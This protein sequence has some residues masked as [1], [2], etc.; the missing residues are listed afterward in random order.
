MSGQIT[1]SW[2]GTVLTITS[3]SGTSSADLKG[4]KGDD[5]ARGAQGAQGEQYKPIS[6]VD[7]LTDAEREDI[8]QNT[9]N[10][11]DFPVDSINGKTGDVV[12]NSA[13][14]GARANNWM[15]TAEEVGARANNW[16]PT[17][18]EVGAATPA[19]VN[20]VVN[21]AVKKAAPINLL[22][23]SD[24]RNPVNQR[25]NNSYHDMGYTIDRWYISESREINVLTN[26]IEI[27]ANDIVGGLSQKVERMAVGDVVTFAAQDADG[28]LY[29][30][31]TALSGDIDA[32]I[33]VG[34][35]VKLR[36]ISLNGIGIFSIS[37]IDFKRIFQWAALYEGE[38]TE[39][40]LP[41]Y[42]PKGYA[43]ELL[44]CQRY[45]VELDH[46]ALGTGY[47]STTNDATIFINPPIQM[48]IKPSVIFSG[49]EIIARF[50]G[51]EFA[52]HDCALYAFDKGNS[53]T[54]RLIGYL[55]EGV[56][57]LTVIAAYATS[58]VALSADL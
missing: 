33:D 50:N 15:P 3:D 52:M 40:T 56:Q 31:S 25:G 32:W 35:G 2:N 58:K 13:D 7:Y 6:G 55:H 14:V 38:Y 16:M 53:T 41:E 5:G 39:E 27:S 26:G 51:T 48:R 46:W 11:I 24:F 9:I 19:D 10:R 54:M 23:N 34:H 57:P 17:A 47:I 4:A 37:V 36:A 43:N 30:L 49:G 18:A 20:N 12:L 28:N 21:N 45:Y 22:D 44:E 8:Y 42:H 1:H 29:V